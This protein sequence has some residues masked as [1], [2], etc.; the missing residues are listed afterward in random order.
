MSSSDKRRASRRTWIVVLALAPFAAGL[1]LGANALWER[2]SRLW[3]Y[4]RITETTK[5]I[6][7]A[8]ARYL[9]T[10]E[11]TQAELAE[12]A[13]QAKQ[14]KDRDYAVL[15]E[16]AQAWDTGNTPEARRLL[17][18]LVAHGTWEGR[19]EGRTRLAWLA[20]ADAALAARP[21]EEQQADATLLEEVREAA[22]A[23][24]ASKSIRARVEWR[25]RMT[26]LE[27]KA[28]WQPAG[29][30]ASLSLAEESG[31]ILATLLAIENMKRDYPLAPATL[32]IRA[33]EW[34]AKQLYEG[35]ANRG[36]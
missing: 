24:P 20:E 11:S 9:S 12:L 29:A 31:D 23:A 10:H 26:K 4:S 32:Q 16:A 18:W 13:R 33:H 8:R 19:R 7:Q 5:A 17:E 34:I 27:E 21:A 2:H 36:R 30:V 25:E 3:P 1:G 6:V 28:R 35:Q 22:R 15:N 14:P